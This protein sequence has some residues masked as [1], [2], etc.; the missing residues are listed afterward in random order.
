LDT[1]PITVIFN[2]CLFNG[3]K[4]MPDGSIRKSFSKEEKEI[5]A[6]MVLPAMKNPDSRFEEKPAPTIADAFPIGSQVAY[7][8]PDYYGSQGKIVAHNGTTSVDVEVE[9]AHP[10]P[11]FSMLI[12]LARAF[13]SCRVTLISQFF[14]V[15][16][17]V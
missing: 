4:R 17:F 10:E 16:V 12:I 13:P 7:I 5:P 2:V 9:A 14:V 8:G 6:Q 3:M 11:T 15:L 1:G